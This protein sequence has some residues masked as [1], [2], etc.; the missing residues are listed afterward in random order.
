VLFIKSQDF[1]CSVEILVLEEPMETMKVKTVALPGTHDIN[2]APIKPIIDHPFVQMLR[3]RHQLD[4]AHL[5]FPC[6]NH[7]RFEHSLGTYSLTLE[8]AQFWVRDGLISV[9]KGRDLSLF[10][11]LHDIGHGPY[12]HCC[13]EIC[14]TDHEQNGLRLLDKLRKEIEAVGGNFDFIRS[15]MMHEE[16][17]SQ[18]V[19]HHPLGTDK[20]D[21]IVR[22][23][24]R[25]N[26][27]VCIPTGLILNYSHFLDGNM[28]IDAKICDEVMQLQRSYF[29]MYKR[30]YFR[31]ACLLVKRLLQKMFVALMQDDA[32]P[33]RE[34]I[35][36][37]LVD[38]QLDSLCLSSRNRQ[39]Q[40]LYDHL[41]RRELPKVAIVLRPDRYV[42]HERVCGKPVR[43]EGVPWNV[44]EKFER[45]S[46]PL[47]VSGL[48]KAIAEIAN[49]PEDSV[50]LVPIVSYRRFFPKD[51][52][53]HD[54]GK[55]VGT[56]RSLY[57]RHYEALG[58]L[59]EDYAAVRIAVWKEY[60]ERL[61]EKAV[62]QKVVDYLVSLST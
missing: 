41:L 37:T 2:I 15:L 24:S 19:V 47:K 57:P 35:L 1:E 23:A 39:V 9:E 12:S 34:D 40:C 61:S 29:Y 5:V 8:R 44:L 21:Y 14:S 30:V 58:E 52:P 3:K 56:L 33:L 51:I 60:R 20:L 50:F 7:S 16:P 18:A 46:S 38:S 54:F 45:L 27:A 17:L 48:E 53:V 13:E 6:A 59:A 49:I 11:L 62:S 31:K 25:T 55:P 28:A 43:V 26:E 4:S 10:G 32:T 22:D 42:S 36:W